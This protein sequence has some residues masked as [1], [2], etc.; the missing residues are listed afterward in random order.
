MPLWYFE[1]YDDHLEI[2]LSDIEDGWGDWTAEDFINAS[3]QTYEDF[4]EIGCGSRLGDQMY[5][6]WKTN[7]RNV[8]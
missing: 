7:Y 8:G 2:D 4:F 5:D 3:W 6:R 1:D